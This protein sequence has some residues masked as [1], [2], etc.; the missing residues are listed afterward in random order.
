MQSIK[1]S[2]EAGVISAYVTDAEGRGAG[3]VARVVEEIDFRADVWAFMQELARAVHSESKTDLRAQL[4]ASL[5]VAQEVMWAFDDER[6]DSL[7]LEERRVQRH[8]CWAW[9]ALRIEAAKSDAKAIQA[10]FTKPVLQ[11]AGLRYQVRARSH[12]GSQRVC[13]RLDA[14][15]RSL[16]LAVLEGNAFRRYGS[17][18]A[19]PLDAL[20]RALR[21]GNPTELGRAL[22]GAWDQTL[23][24]RA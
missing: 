10:L 5:R 4:L 12:D 23:S 19:T 8:L 17:T 21:D 7:E 11:L 15:G 22:R 2:L 3:D 18:P 20:A 1:P 14:R 16:E 13:L 6:E 24:V 9:M